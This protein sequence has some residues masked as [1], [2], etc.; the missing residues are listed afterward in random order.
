M[1]SNHLLFSA[2]I[3]P[4]FLDLQCRHYASE[5]KRRRKFVEKVIIKPTK[6]KKETVDLYADMNAR[7][8]KTRKPF[9]GVL[10]GFKFKNI[11]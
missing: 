7:Y 8:V 2:R 11:F 10:D 3:L 6:S 9:G 4:F 1:H 5:S